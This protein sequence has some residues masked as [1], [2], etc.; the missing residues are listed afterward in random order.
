MSAAEFLRHRGV[1]YELI[2]KILPPEIEL[3]PDEEFHIE[4]ELR[5]SG[6]L[7]REEKIAE[8]M[9][10][11]DNSK[12]PENFDYDSVKGMRAECRE[13]LKHF[14]PDSLGHALR[15]SGVTPTDVQLI[16]VIIARNML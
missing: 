4:T 9:K 14:R 6:Y 12:I 15:I 11:L 10:N 3:N 7:E 5:Y 1:T 2:K 8:R 13:K 16:S